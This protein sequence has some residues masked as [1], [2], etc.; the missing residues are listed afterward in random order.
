MY[1]IKKSHY[2]IFAEQIA[3]QIEGRDWFSGVLEVASDG[4]KH[5]LELV[6]VVYRDAK[7]GEVVDVADVWWDSCTFTDESCTNP[8]KI[9]DFDFAKLYKELVG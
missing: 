9:N 5:R 4:L 6:L 7:S 1:R 2:R 8:P 3:Q